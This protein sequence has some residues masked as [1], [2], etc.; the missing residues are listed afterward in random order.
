MHRDLPDSLT[1]MFLLIAQQD[2][3][4]FHSLL[5]NAFTRLTYEEKRSELDFLKTP[6]LFGPFDSELR[7][8][9]TPLN[10]VRQRQ[11]LLEPVAAVLNELNL[12]HVFD[13]KVKPGAQQKHQTTPPAEEP[14]IRFDLYIEGSRIRGLVRAKK[15]DIVLTL[16]FPALTHLPPDCLNRLLCD[17][18]QNV[19]QGAFLLDT[20]ST[21]GSHCIYY[22]HV[23]PVT[24]KKT[25]LERSS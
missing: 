2:P 9:L 4:V 21:S 19:K 13:G 5:V 16:S 14:R 10:L 7:D 11:P 3:N 23:L 8:K 24:E 15:H 22:K 25:F 6:G 17:E 12:K 20:S 18:N 1:Y